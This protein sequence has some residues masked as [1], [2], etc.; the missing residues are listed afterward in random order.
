MNLTR[1]PV[2]TIEPR[3]VFAMLS[4]AVACAS[5]L[6]AYSYTLVIANPLV[7]SDVWRFLDG[8][9]GR[10]ID[11]GFSWQDV[12]VEPDPSDTNFP[13]YKSFLMF[14]TRW[15]G[16]DLRLEAVMAVL[17]AIAC[18]LLLA[19]TAAAR[20]FAAW[21]TRECA[22]LAALSLAMLSLNS[23]NLYA[24][25]LALAWYVPVLLACAYFGAA[26]AARWRLAAAATFALGVL[27]DEFAYPVVAA[28]L[29]A[30]AALRWRDWR[31]LRLPAAAI[32]AGLAASRIFY[33]AWDATAPPELLAAAGDPVLARSWGAF[34]SADAWKA[35]VLPLS[36]SLVHQDNLVPVFG[37]HAQAA[38]WTLALG[39]VAAHVWFWWRTW[40]IARSGDSMRKV[41]GAADGDRA[42][43][44]AV[45]M[46]LFFYAM[47]AAVV[48]QRVPEHG[49]DY[50][51]QPRY[52]LFYQLNLVALALLLYSHGNGNGDTDAAVAAPQRTQRIAAPIALAL[53][54][55]LQ[56]VLSA[57]AWAQAKYVSAYLQHAAR[58]MGRLAEDPSAQIQC[59]PI[60][61]AC[62]FPADK[63]RRVMARLVGYRLN[64]FSPN[65]QAMHRLYPDAAAIPP[66]VAGAKAA[67]R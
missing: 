11:H 42:A 3:S 43:W 67:P 50:L 38:R 37:T 40:R 59:L 26:H 48:L 1:A 20:P 21:R 57:Q 15:F 25:P 7:Q 5:I 35:V 32:V 9:L 8:F 41:A 10:F 4:I 30:W 44:L 51:D 49:F 58:D 34:L 6:N 18:V 55:A 23:P 39:L 14:N 65:F 28:T 45:A 24:W 61:R 36:D 16:L 27:L 66:D 63:R 22:L 12:F 13:I 19:R 17:A 46:M 62:D 60:V 52:V 53:I 54:V 31:A 64:L 29:L 47:V 56:V 33:G 2:R